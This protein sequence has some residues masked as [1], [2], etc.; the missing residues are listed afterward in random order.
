MVA[1]WESHLQDT[2]TP[3]VIAGDVTLAPCLPQV[4]LFPA[5]TS[6]WLLSSDGAAI[7]TAALQGMHLDAGAVPAPAMQQHLLAAICAAAPA[8]EAA[9]VADVSSELQQLGAA[10]SGL[11][12]G[13]Q[14]GDDGVMAAAARA[15]AALAPRLQQ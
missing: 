13:A 8:H 9:G 1:L 2:Q 3:V 4:T 14:G 6:S 15:E 7:L 10:L 5:D 11:K 12:L